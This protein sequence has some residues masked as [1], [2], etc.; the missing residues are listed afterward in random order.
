MKPEI[1]PQA[2]TPTS[3]GK[4]IG[5]YKKRKQTWQKVDTAY[6]VPSVLVPLAWFRFIPS[7]LECQLE[8]LALYTCIKAMECAF[9]AMAVWNDITVSILYPIHSQQACM[10]N[11]VGE[12]TI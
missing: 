12:C 3:S 9:V 5:K 8:R 4:S 10:V 7:C 2:G 11:D 1:Q 6:L